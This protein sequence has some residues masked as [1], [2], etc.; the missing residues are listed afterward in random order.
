VLTLGLTAALSRAGLLLGFAAGVGSLAILAVSPA[1]EFRSRAS[2]SV[3][4]GAI[5]VAVAI[6]AT[7]LVALERR[8][9]L[10]DSGRA[11]IHKVTL[12]AASAFAPL[13][14]GLGTFVPVYA[15]C[16]GPENVSSS[17]TNRAHNDWLELWLEAGVPAAAL[18]ALFLAWLGI[19]AWA[20]WSPQDHE[21]SLVD[22][23]LARAATVTI[24]LVLLHSVA[25]YPLR[26]SANL[27][28]FALAC[29]L[30]IPASRQGSTA[31]GAVPSG[32]RHRSRSISES[33]AS[34]RRQRGAQT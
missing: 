8:E 9:S 20:A 11:E 33:G 27:T 25:D 17:Y 31:N 6:Q 32:R 30:L 15:M 13:G 26:T 16:E 12:K 18:A 2:R 29:A 14:S 19:R 24:V 10:E 34:V 23:L 22:A 28:V 21:H 3:S 4:L 1:V 7:L 5:L